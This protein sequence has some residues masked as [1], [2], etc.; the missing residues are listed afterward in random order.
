MPSFYEIT[1]SD[2]NSENTKTESFEYLK[3]RLYCSGDS[4][5]FFDE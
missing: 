1:W 3:V 2:E 4:E 5:D